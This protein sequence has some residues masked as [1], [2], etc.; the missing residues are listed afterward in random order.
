MEKLLIVMVD[1]DENYLM[2]LELKFTEELKNRAEIVVITSKEYLNLFFSDPKEID[3]LLINE[4]LFTEDLK[5]HNI[6]NIFILSEDEH[7]ESLE[8]PQNICKYTS[9]KEI[10]NLIISN[11]KSVEINEDGKNVENKVIVIYS[12]IGGSGKT[13]L[14]A[15]ISA[16]L[17][18]N[19]KKALYINTEVLQNFSNIL[20]DNASPYASKSFEK[21][22]VEKDFNIVQKLINS[23]G[24]GEFDYILPFKQALSSL[25][26]DLEKYIYL[27]SKIK[28]AEIYDYI[29]VDTSI[30]LTNEKCHLMSLAD[31][32]VIIAN[33]DKNS[34][35]KI[36]SLLDN[37]DCSN[38]NKFV[39]VCNKFAK[40]NENYLIN[41]TIKNNFVVKENISLITEENLSIKEL[42]KNNE[43]KKLSY[44]LI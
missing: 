2:P 15:G 1:E 6:K 9:V 20:F 18:K 24:K 7:E 29:I 8:S 39:F 35:I 33:Q 19:N 36:D 12:P 17:N 5:R 37:I 27:I 14:S 34:A 28:E 3:I 4:N 40:G 22:L 38:K 43:L 11:V 21:G 13:I 30:E 44:D 10:Y 16:I 31:K 41:N 32:V 26:I 42:E 23:I 25:E